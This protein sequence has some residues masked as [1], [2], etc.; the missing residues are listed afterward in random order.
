[1]YKYA[2]EHTYKHKHKYKYK[3]TYKYK[4]MYEYKYMYMPTIK[5]NYY[6]NNLCLLSYAVCPLS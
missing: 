3:H 5:A 1:M 6:K 4:Y 2:Y